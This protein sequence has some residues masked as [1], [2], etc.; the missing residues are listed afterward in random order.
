M[1]PMVRPAPPRPDVRAGRAGQAGR[2]G[3]A[4]LLLAAVLVAGLAVVRGPADELAATG[5]ETGTARV[6][7]AYEQLFTAAAARTGISA[8]SL[9]AQ[10]RVE[11]GFD[12]AAESP[13][14]AQG[15]MQFLPATWE[16]YGV[17]GDGDGDTDVHSPADAVPAAAA[18]RL[19]LA[20][21][22]ADLPGDPERIVLAA[23]N[24]GPEAVR[25]AGGV[26]AYDE[27]RGYVQSVQEWTARYAYL[28]EPS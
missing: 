5:R 2:A 7:A 11:S 18:Y 24:A 1:H 17:D 14:G 22:L 4:L 13:V 8:A 26:P 15:M 27:T 23:Y 28:D 16:A 25:R 21:Q 6:P 19:A 3:R 10:A 9:A 20:R 12:A